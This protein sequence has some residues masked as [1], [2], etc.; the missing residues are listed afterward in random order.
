MN[1]I[2][3]KSASILCKC[4]FKYKFSVSKDLFARE[5]TTKNKNI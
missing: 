2:R 4:H 5:F 3:T 1:Y